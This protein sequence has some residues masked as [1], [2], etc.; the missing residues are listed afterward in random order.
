MNRSRRFESLEQREINRETFVEDWPEAGLI[1][2]DGPAD[3]Q[4]GLRLAQGRVVEMDG[5][6]RAGF[7]ALD[8]FI[9]DHGLDLNVA[10]QAMATP[11][12]DIARMLVDLS[13]PRAE[14]LRLA[15][16]CT[17]AKLV[18]I[19][20]HM[21][22]L[23]MMV[24][25]AKMRA[26]RTPANQAHVTNRREHPALLAADAAE[27]AQRGFAEIETTVGVARFAPLNA[28]AILIGSQTGRGGVLT[29][30]SVEES[31]GLQLA[32]KGLTTYAE[33]LSV[34]GT[35]GAFVDG[36]DT[37]WSKAFLSAAYAS[38]GVKIRFTSGTG[39]EALMGHAQG[40]SMLYLEARCLLITRGAGSQGVQNGSISCIALPE[41]LSG[42]VRVVLAEN[43]LAS[44]LGLEVA[45]GNDALASHSPIRKTAK[46]MLQ[47]IP[48]TD[49][50]FSGY[51]AVP[52]RDNLF[53]G[54]NFDADDLDDFSVLQRDM[55]VD[56]G[57]RPITEQQALAIRREAALA[58]Q[59][60][61]AELGFPAVSQAE[62]EAAV[63]AHGSEDMPAR[64]VAADLAAADR[65]L[66]G[67]ETVMAVI[68]ALLRRGFDRLAANVLE[69]GRQ[70]VAGDYLQPAGIFD[71]HFRVASAINDAN[72][73][74]GPG[75]GYRL[76]QARWQELRQLPQVKSPREFIAG[77]VGT[78]SAMLAE[79]GPARPGSLP[80]VVVA[81]G[82]AFGTELT[83]TING[84]SH[85]DVLA[86]ILTGVAA[87]GLTA[88]VVKVYH[89]SDCA[90]IGQSAA[91]LSSTGI[92]IGLQSRGTTIIHQRGLPRLNNLELFP[93][94]P[95]LTLETYQSIGRNAARYA[96]GQRTTPVPVQVD[97]WARLRLI[98]KTA[99]LHRRETEMVRQQPPVELRFDW[100]PDL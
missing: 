4:P 37:P 69:M 27:A 64:D 80:E 2:A 30:C 55:Q 28:L 10:E 96:Q 89:S 16:G 81:V 44:M 54:G 36:D 65:F 85:E 39:S 79:L 58:I 75:T 43:L 48:G 51:S 90:A 42:G 26:R 17:P 57:T 72:D 14:V 5:R 12:I 74:R 3:P 53:G 62:V 78:P 91:D 38:R 23:E 61:Y 49:F 21:N 63:I 18:D 70:R 99:L 9:A 24:G 35:E 60:V 88:R 7:D 95:S 20:R 33:T 25:L 29:Q 68:D 97:N 82:P 73:Y 92:G 86:A 8:F 41:S 47:F 46:L 19:V 15:G 22:V 6:P 67:S 94:S 1:A 45:S 98:V 50:I 77:N 93:Q 13:V 76:S 71:Q 83:R 11:S 66:N 31:L 84:L 52:K 59:A 40:C 100:E 87:E 34:Y 56:G 32:M